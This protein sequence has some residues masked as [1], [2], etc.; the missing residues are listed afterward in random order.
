MLTHIHTQ[1]LESGYMDDDPR[2]LTRVME[3]A[4]FANRYTY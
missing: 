4:V 1:V 3:C 2:E